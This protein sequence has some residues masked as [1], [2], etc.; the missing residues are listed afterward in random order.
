MYVVIPLPKS[1]VMMRYVYDWS[2]RWARNCIG[3]NAL[4]RYPFHYPAV[5]WVA[6]QLVTHHLQWMAWP[7]FDA[8][9]DLPV[10]YDTSYAKFWTF[11]ILRFISRLAAT[12]SYRA[13][14][15][16]LFYSI[17]RVGKLEIGNSCIIGN[18]TDSAEIWT[19]LGDFALIT[20]HLLIICTL[21]TP[22]YT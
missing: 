3:A 16:L 11:W 18:A 21:K 9:H 19:Q 15:T 7:G 14:S 5:R 20:A 10:F 12:Q 8:R 13:Q 17:P 22:R 6:G 4:C 2:F 1:M